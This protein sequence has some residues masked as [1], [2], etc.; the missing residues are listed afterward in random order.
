MD[1]T[2]ESDLERALLADPRLCAGLAW[3]APRQGHPEGTVATHVAAILDRIPAGDPLRAD[4][5]FL[6][7][8][9]D[10]FK[11]EVRPHERW[12]PDNDHATR[13]RRHA[14]RHTEDERLLTALELHSEPYW[15]WRNAGAPEE[16]L[17]P[18]LGRL[19]DSDLFAGFVEL[20]AETDGKDLTFLW[21]FR[22][23]LALARWLP[24]HTATEP[25]ADAGASGDVVYVKAFAVDPRQQADVARAAAL[26][27]AERPAGLPGEGEAL[28]SDDGTRVLLA[29]RW[30]ASRG[31]LLDRDGDFA[32]EALAAHP[33][34]ASAQAAEARIFR[35]LG[36]RER[37]GEPAPRARSDVGVSRLPPRDRLMVRDD[38]LGDAEPMTETRTNLAH[39]G[40]AASA[41]PHGSVEIRPLERGD[42]ERLAA[43]FARLGEET[44]RRRFLSS[45]SH[46]TERDLDALTDIDHHGHEALA[47]VE[48]RTGQLVGVARYIRLPREARA[49]EVAVAVDDGWQRRGIGRRLLTE[50]ADR[51]RTEGITRLTAYVGIENGPV[52]RWIARLGGVALA[53]D[54]DAILYSVSLDPPSDRR[55]AALSPAAAAAC[56]TSA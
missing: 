37:T 16:A 27:V 53:Q 52:R 20:D 21:W 8:V 54:G 41:D 44:R 28:T 7:L 45:A 2:A 51:A 14:E 56:V 22:R 15:I 1:I 24:S 40:S 18:L 3:G 49:A 6:A 4:L 35:P 25:A 13:A 39:L 55:A 47:A 9:H 12:S 42:R 23:E 31:E 38:A 48:P 46:L 26:V 32:R 10:S 34:L 36:R 43:A 29:W 5:R 33:V 19:P 30:R 50:L 11:H 17:Q